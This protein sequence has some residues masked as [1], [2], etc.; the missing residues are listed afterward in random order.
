MCLGF[1]TLA[2]TPAGAQAASDGERRY[3]T[4]TAPAI[5]SIGSGPVGGVLPASGQRSVETT[6]AQV[7]ASQG[8]SAVVAAAQ[9]QAPV[10]GLAFTGADI[11]MLVTIGLSLT[12]LGFV[13][14]RRARPRPMRQA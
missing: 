12:I 6:P 4:L 5:T 7:L 14:A 9:G 3:V 13:M 11:L 8:S 10:Q 1:V 2:G